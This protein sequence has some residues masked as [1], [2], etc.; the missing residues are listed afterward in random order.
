MPDQ[1]SLWRNR[2]YLRLFTASVVNAVGTYMSAVAIPL[3]VLAC[4]YGGAR[5]GAVG[6]V[7]IAASIVLAIPCSTLA[8][9]L[10]YRRLLILSY[11]V[12]MVAIGSIPF[13]LHVGTPRFGQ[14]VVVAL[15]QGAGSAI[16]VP[17][18]SIS[19]RAAVPHDQLTLAYSRSQSMMAVEILT[20]PALA[21]AFFAINKALPCTIDAASYAIAAV[22]VLGLPARTAQGNPDEAHSAQRTRQRAEL[23]AGFRWILKQ[24]LLR[25]ILLQSSLLNCIGAA[26]EISLIVAL[27]R[28]GASSQAVGITLS[29][30]GLGSLAGSLIVGRILKLLPGALIDLI[31]GIT[32]GLAL[33]GL[34]VH[35]SVFTAAA[36][37]AAM[38][39]LSPAASVRS[40]EMT[41]SAAP[42]E[43]IGRITGAESMILRVLTAVGPSIGGLLCGLLSVSDGWI[44]LSAACFATLL[45]FV[46]LPWP[47]LTGKQTLKEAEHDDA[48]SISVA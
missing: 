31:C 15:I 40:S 23:L 9:R 26:L 6:T 27:R 43:L 47:L 3:L 41:T 8:D 33:L 30:L 38:M 46:G 14:F 22:L 13:V 25:R 1:P 35:T 12:R 28:Q 19:T 32:W 39:F 5:A 7:E 20:A 16:A 18:L 44:V 34:A 24:P 37:G 48:R 17:L 10:E 4:G 2:A 21:G 29:C 11:L 45:A 36:G 42:E